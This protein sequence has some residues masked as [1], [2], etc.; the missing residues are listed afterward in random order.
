MNKPK[1]IKTFNHEL[2][3]W[4]NSY[5][6]EALQSQLQRCI[7]RFI[8][9]S[10]GYYAV[11]F[12]LSHKHSLL[13][14]SRVKHRF[15]GVTNLSNQATKQSFVTGLAALPVEGASVDLVIANHVLEMSTTPH[16]VVREIDRILT[17]DGEC[18]LIGFNPISL[19]GLRHFLRPYENHAFYTQKRV[20]D[21]FSVLGFEVK[22]TQTLSYQPHWAG[23]FI[24]KKTQCLERWGQRWSL[25]FGRIYVLHLKKCTTPL[26][27]TLRFKAP[28]ILTPA[29]GMAVNAHSNSQAT[30]QTH[31]RN[32]KES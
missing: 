6:G 27:P 2:E 18:V 29:Q 19:M 14:E 32:I 9:Q 15:C 28:R 4:Y 25:P 8:E 23:H 26:M 5:F 7:T 3:Q 16:Q 11:E 12:G 10:F 21:W 20:K 17:P 31:E 30:K 1:S 13:A 22:Q 24:Y